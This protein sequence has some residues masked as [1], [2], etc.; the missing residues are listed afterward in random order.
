MK[1]IE[2]PIFL[3]GIPLKK[4]TLPGLSSKARLPPGLTGGL[5]SRLAQL[6]GIQGADGATVQ[7]HDSLGDVSKGDETNF[8]RLSW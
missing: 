4:P 8:G 3:G 7:P 1:I 2:I 6:E 5:A